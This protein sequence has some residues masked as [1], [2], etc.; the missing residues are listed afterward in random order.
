[1]TTPDTSKLT[2]DRKI[3]VEIWNDA[4]FPA[5]RQW[6]CL[7]EVADKLWCNSRKE[8]HLLK[9]KV[10]GSLHVH[11][12]DLEASGILILDERRQEVLF[13]SRTSDCKELG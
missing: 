8:A 9:V 3:Y 7:G 2:F 1:M 10:T 11:H 4:L 5:T 12:I 13:D 6:N